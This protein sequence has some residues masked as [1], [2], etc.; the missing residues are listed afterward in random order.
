[1]R[2]LILA[3]ALV[4]NVPVQALESEITVLGVTLPNADLG[5]A[6]SLLGSLV[7]YWPTTT[8]VTVKLANGGSALPMTSTTSGDHAAQLTA[9]KAAALAAN[10]RTLHSADVIMFFATSFNDLYTCGYAPQL[11][12]TAAGAHAFI[13]DAQGIDRAG[14]EESYAA[15]LAT[16]S[17]PCGSTI[18][19]EAAIHEFG[20]LFGAGHVGPPGF[21]L[22]P[23]SHA[24]VAVHPYLGWYKTIMGPGGSASVCALSALD[25]AWTRVG[26][27]VSI[28]N[29]FLRR[30]VLPAGRKSLRLRVV[31]DDSVH[32]HLCQRPKLPHQGQSLQWVFVLRSVE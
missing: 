15:I 21:F 5:V 3:L 8:G 6:Q 18:V 31:D 1:M 28:G 2:R 17:P 23:D 27:H 32:S 19:P 24:L 4:V 25:G 7:T 9:A 12:W 10:I 20:H 29:P 30:V 11:N 26:G 13:A 16:T 14:A 22:F